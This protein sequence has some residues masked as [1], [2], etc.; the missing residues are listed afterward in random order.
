VNGQPREGDY[1]EAAA[2][3]R[4]LRQFLRRSEQAT[5]AHG[6]TPEQYEFLL[7]LH[8]SPK[9]QATIGHLCVT[10]A[11]KQSAVTQLARRA[12]NQGLITRQLSDTDAR[13][14]YLQLTKKGESRLAAV[15]TELGAERAHLLEILGDLEHSTTVSAEPG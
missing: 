6:L 11:R 12:Q 1:R 8:V 4:A 9:E 10:L 2:V 3:R 13:V 15:L 14:R 5:R 7:L